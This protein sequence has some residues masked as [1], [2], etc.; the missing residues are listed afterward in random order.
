MLE[1]L[2][3]LLEFKGLLADDESVVGEYPEAE[4]AALWNYIYI[5]HEDKS[6]G[7]HNPSYTKALLESSIAAVQPSDESVAAC[8]DLNPDDACTLV[9]ED[10]AEV[11][12]VCTTVTTLLVCA[13]VPVEEAP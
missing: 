1:E 4:A 2:A 8:T 9:G 10:G 7:V 13:P 5:K 12:G 11:A 3:A 6:M